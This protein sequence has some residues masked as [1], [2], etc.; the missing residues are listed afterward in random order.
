[1]M[2]AMYAGVA[3]LKTHQ[4]KMDVIGNNIANVNTVAFKSSSTTFSELMYQNVSGA[5]GPSATTGR[6]GVNAKQI[7]LGVTTGSTSV[8]ITSPGS[9]QTTGDGFDLMITGDSF[10]VVN[11]GATNLFTKAGA[12]YIDGAGNLAMKSTGYNVMGWQVDPTTGDIRKDMVSPLKIMTEANM[13]SPPEAT[14]NGTCGGVL[15]KNATAVHSDAGYAMSLSF[16]DALGY[17]YTAKF[18]VKATNTKGEYSV[19]LDDIMDVNG[20]SIKD[21]YNVNSLD[22]IVSWGEQITQQNTANYYLKENVRFEYDAQNPDNSKYFKGMNFPACVT[23]AD[24]QVS[25]FTYKVTGAANGNSIPTQATMGPI[26]AK[27]LEEKYKVTYD[28]ATNKYYNGSTEIDEAGWKN[29]FKVPDAATLTMNQDADGTMTFSFNQDFTL[30]DGAQATG[31]PSRYEVEITQ[32]EAYEGLDTSAGG[33]TTYQINVTPTGVAQ[34]TATR[35][36]TGNILKFDVDSGLFVSIG[37]NDKSAVLNFAENVTNRLGENQ[38]LRSFSDISIDFSTT[39]WYDNSGSSTMG[40]DPGAVDGET[41]KG[42]KLGDLI[43]LSVSND[44]TIWGSYDNGNTTLLGQIAVAVFAN[45][46]GLEKM[47][48]NCYQTTLNSGGFDG[49]GQDITADG[50][51]MTSGQLE[52]SNVDLSTEFTEMITTQRGFQANSRI[53]TTSD[54]LLE[55]LINLKR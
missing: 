15:D 34:V 21:I 14:T 26:S 7:G 41:G 48:E 45:P 35:V 23:D 1:M 11:N 27:D 19:E 38:S 18:S 46:S 49:I 12:F 17:Q 4:T 39:K 50:G 24:Q 2:R 9:S 3:G 20:T 25:G 16:T 10:F 37:G 36:F 43:G 30:V 40:M 54:T 42:K 28:A 22:E 32:A 31:D 5:S 13:T 52:M 55:E 33:D 44:G 6:G 51:K 29:I 47:G 8:N 53:I